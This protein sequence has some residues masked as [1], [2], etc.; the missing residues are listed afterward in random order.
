MVYL[1]RPIP[2][3]QHASPVLLI[4]LCVC[5][6]LIYFTI[7]MREVKWGSEVEREPVYRVLQTELYVNEVRACVAAFLLYSNKIISNITNGSSF[8]H[9]NN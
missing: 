9:V 3:V 5:L 8:F 1:P 7:Y 4:S 6:N 2:A